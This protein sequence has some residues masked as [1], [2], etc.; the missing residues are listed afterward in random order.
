MK[1]TILMNPRVTGI[2][3]GLIV[4]ASFI[5]GAVA[6]HELP[7]VIATH[8]DAA[9]H[10]NGTAPRVVATFVLPILMLLFWLLWAVLPH[11][12]PI[13][14]GFKGFR[15]VYDFAWILIVAFMAYVYALILE[16]DM[17]VH[18][19]MLQSIMPA[20]AGLF[21]MLGALMPMTKRNWFIGVRTP[22][23]LSSDEVWKKTHQVAAVLFILSGLCIF[24]GSYAPAD[25]IVW[26]IVLP[27]AL[28]VI[29]A[30]AY[31][32]VLYRKEKHL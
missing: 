4:V 21:V 26:Y 17:G 3:I 16:A 32:Y 22:W 14:P 1:Y 25:T 12:D 6:Y 13:A 19:N 10:V 31:S 8:W 30:V 27:I 20:L 23:T 9:G 15:H 2:L 28:S 11:V 5:T 18:I 7:S 29:G 24:A